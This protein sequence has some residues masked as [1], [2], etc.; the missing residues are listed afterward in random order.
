V[1]TSTVCP[2]LHTLQFPKVFDKE[3]ALISII[4]DIKRNNNLKFFL[5]T[6]FISIRFKYFIA[7]IYQNSTRFVPQ[8]SQSYHNSK[9]FNWN[10]FQNRMNSYVMPSMPPDIR[11]QEFQPFM[12]YQSYPHN[13]QNVRN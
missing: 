11:Y 9:N 3:F 6:K 13:N 7:Y 2:L 4:L 1:V 12:N 10:T 8:V 5:K